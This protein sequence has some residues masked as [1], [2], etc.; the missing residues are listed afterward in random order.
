MMREGLCFLCAK[1][2]HLLRDF[3]N[4]GKG[5]PTTAHILELKEELKRLKGSGRKDLPKN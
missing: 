4:K 5:K 2:G 1:Q 3:P